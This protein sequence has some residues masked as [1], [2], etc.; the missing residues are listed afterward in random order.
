MPHPIPHPMTPH[1]I[2]RTQYT[3]PNTPHPIH[4]TQYTP[5]N[6]LTLS[7]PTPADATQRTRRGHTA[8]VHARHLRAPQ[9]FFS[10]PPIFPICHT[11]YPPYISEYDCFSASARPKH[12]RLFLSTTHFPHMPHPISPIYQRILLL[13]CLSSTQAMFAL[14]LLNSACWLAFASVAGIYCKRG[15]ARAS[16]V[17]KRRFGGGGG[18]GNKSDHKMSDPEHSLSDSA[19]GGNKSKGSGPENGGGERS[20]VVAKALRN[21]QHT[22]P[23]PISRGVHYAGVERYGDHPR[24]CGG[25][26]DGGARGGGGG[27]G[28][29][30][31]VRGS[32]FGLGSHA[33][34][35]SSL[36]SPP[37]SRGPPPSEL[38][39]LLDSQSRSHSRAQ[40]R[41]AELV[42][43]SVGPLR[44]CLVNH[45]QQGVCTAAPLHSLEECSEK[46]SPASS[47]HSADLSAWGYHKDPN[48]HPNGRPP[49]S[50]HG[51]EPDKMM[52][53]GPAAPQCAAGAHHHQGYAYRA[54]G[55]RGHSPGDGSPISP[56]TLSPITPVGSPWASPAAAQTLRTQQREL[57][58]RNRATSPQPD[59]GV[60]PHLLQA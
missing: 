52:G 46:A 3:P 41:H 16:H 37:S 25:N 43:D 20:S 13:F 5:P 53:W 24:Q 35:R 1:P 47:S 19:I 12:L 60:P 42:L 34:Q 32:L 9:A 26:G 54:D 39:S 27:G 7:P 8:N 48:I 51:G 22:L 14:L 49:N 59:G 11:P 17:V 45:H 2:H 6:R 50:Y 38:G 58:V 55:H 44:S 10:K 29:G 56:I 28:G 21:L 36:L 31:S 57:S 23:S 15:G 33:P 4:P 18:S 40:S 30:G